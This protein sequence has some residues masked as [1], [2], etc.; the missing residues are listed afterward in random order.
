MHFEGLLWPDAH[1]FYFHTTTSQS[2]ILFKLPTATK[3]SGKSV[4]HFYISFRSRWAYRDKKGDTID[5]R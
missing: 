1:V 5:S 2:V 4:S 3:Y